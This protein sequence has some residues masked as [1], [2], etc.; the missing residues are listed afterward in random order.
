VASAWRS[1]HRRDRV[2]PTASH[3]A[4]IPARKRAAGSVG[5]CG[6]GRT[7]TDGQGIMR[8]SG[9]TVVR[10]SAT[11]VI[12]S[13]PADLTAPNPRLEAIR[14]AGS[15]A[16]T[17]TITSSEPWSNVKSPRIADHSR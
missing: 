2:L 8:T 9:L 12:E 15:L 7:R 17:G 1:G 5:P 14:P 13:E 4:V 16:Q 6:A 11:A 3:R 10:M